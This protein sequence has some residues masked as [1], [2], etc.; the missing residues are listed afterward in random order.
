M[1]DEV[2][3]ESGKWTPKLE[4][5]NSDGSFSYAARLGS[6]YRIGE[7]VTVSCWLNIWKVE[8]FPEGIAKITGLPYP[9]HLINSASTPVL[10][11]PYSKIALEPE[12]RL[13]GLIRTNTIELFVSNPE[14]GLYYGAKGLPI[15]EGTS[16][17]VTATY[18]IQL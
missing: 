9:E 5:S 4:F 17:F 7:L 12:E 10:I 14:T 16:I 1:L 2:L 13:S 3:F 6:F 18:K 11:G 15:Q 8:T